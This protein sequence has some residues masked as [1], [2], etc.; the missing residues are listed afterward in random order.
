MLSKDATILIGYSGHAF[1]V[2]DAF[3]SQR[4][5]VVGYC[6]AVEKAINPFDLPY[7]GNEFDPAALLLFKQYTFFVAIGDNKIRRKVYVA[8]ISQGFIPS[9]AIHRSASVS[10][11]STQG[12]G[13]LVAA[14]AVINPLADIGDGAICNTGCVVEHENVIGDFAHIGPGAI[15]CGN[16]KV[17]DLSFVGANTVVKQGV[18]IGNN[19]TIG[20]GSVIIRDIPD[21]V[22]VVGNPGRIIK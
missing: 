16:V 7:F 13:V 22:T 2:Y 17:G 19:V 6:D 3:F 18:T 5:T 12:S 4:H 9:S 8:M 10:P 1:V 20:A 11:F 14:G 15:L 21:G